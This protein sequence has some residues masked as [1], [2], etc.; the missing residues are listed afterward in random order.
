MFEDVI[1]KRGH[2]LPPGS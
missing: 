1:R 2:V